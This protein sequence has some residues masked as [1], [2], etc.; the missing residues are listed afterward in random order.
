MWASESKLP[1]CHLLRFFYVMIVFIFWIFQTPCFPLPHHHC[2]YLT[3]SKGDHR[4]VCMWHHWNCHIC[5]KASPSNPCIHYKRWICQ[6]H[7]MNCSASAFYSFQITTAAQFLKLRF[8]D[9]TTHLQSPLQGRAADSDSCNHKQ[10]FS[11]AEPSQQSQGWKTK[12]LRA[13][14]LLVPC[15]ESD[16]MILFVWMYERCSL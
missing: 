16:Q 13:R 14:L 12:A 8:W 11:Q 2:G 3:L 6:Q 1:G 5:L 4:Q 9:R 15:L 10:Q 7:T